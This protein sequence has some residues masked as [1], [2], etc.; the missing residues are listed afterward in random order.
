MD[1]KSKRQFRNVKE[2]LWVMQKTNKHIF[3]K[4]RLW[5]SKTTE[6]VDCFWL[7]SY[8]NLIEL[9]DGRG[10]LVLKLSAASFI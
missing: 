5:F 7:N 6:F 4:L 3:I 1:S 9:K 2:I 10:N 8:V